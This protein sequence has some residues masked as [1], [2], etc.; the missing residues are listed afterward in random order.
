MTKLQENLEGVYDYLQVDCETLPSNQ[1]S[2]VQPFL[3]FV[4]NLN[5]ASRCHRDK[6][7]KTF[8]LVIPFGD[9][10]GGELCLMEAGIVVP[11]QGGDFILF[12]SSALTHF[13]LHYKGQ[14][15]SLVLHTDKEISK[16][17]DGRNGWACNATLR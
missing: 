16:W 12:L 6:G 1:T 9:F 15:G 2:P 14:R 10:E 4:I 3:G 7:D 13:N 11:L 17:T 5:I 8:C